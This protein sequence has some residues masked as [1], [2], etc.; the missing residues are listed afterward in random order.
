[1]KKIILVF[2]FALFLFPVL[3]WA[4]S[5]NINTAG[6][7]ELDN[8]TGVGPAIAQ[9]IIDYRIANGSFKTIEEI[10]NVSGIG[11]ATFLKMK[12][13]I[14]VG[15]E[16]G[17]GG[18]AEVKN[19]TDQTVTSD[20]GTTDEPSVN[21]NQANPTNYSQETF[22][23]GAGRE[24]LATVRTPILF[25]ATQ[26]KKG[27]DT[28]A[29][30][31]SFG[32]GTSATGAKVYHIYQFPGVY[33]VVLNGAIDKNEEAVARTKVTVSEPKIK[34]TD[35]N[36]ELGFVEIMNSS[37]K[38]QNLNNWILSSLEKKYVFPTDTIISPKTSLKIPLDLLG[39]NRK[40][41]DNLNLAYPDGGVV[42]V[43]NSQNG[44][45]SGQLSELKK[46]LA[47][48]KLK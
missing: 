11:D 25:F 1:M 31:W 44:S 48:I 41:L 12:D 13:Q 3:T 14:T 5:V 46:K 29:F 19:A 4:I 34:I 39:F 9:K 43:A 35:V 10:K 21:T 45:S 7:S 27:K 22:K 36:P 18:G 37:D 17:T 24:R 42:S 30:T 2:L 23:I 15:G 40:L 6:L 33:N 20:D 47:K 16:S 28:N 26:S 32:D 38:E 8:I